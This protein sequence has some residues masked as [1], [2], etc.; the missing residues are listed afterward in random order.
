MAGGVALVAL[1]VVVL[2]VM[3]AGLVR[4][5]AKICARLNILLSSASSRGRKPSSSASFRAD[6]TSCGDMVFLL[7]MRARSFELKYIVLVKTLK[8]EC[9]L[10][11]SICE[12]KSE[13]G[14]KTG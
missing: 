12:S 1:G 8:G 14:T 5:M 4:A 7:L 13:H 2:C 11:A 6:M 10:Q 9:R 3:L